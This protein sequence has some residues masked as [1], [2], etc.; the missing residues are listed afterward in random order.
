MTKSTVTINGIEYKGDATSTSMIYATV[1]NIIE[2][3]ATEQ[4]ILAGTT[5]GR[6][7]RTVILV[8]P[9]TTVHATIVD[10]PDD[11]QS[12]QTISDLRGNIDEMFEAYR[13]KHDEPAEE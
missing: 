6:A 3:G 7:Q 8:T 2:S 9:A 1:R 13:P 10:A 4:L 5:G 11:P 12:A